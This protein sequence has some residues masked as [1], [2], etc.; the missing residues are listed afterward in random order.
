MRDKIDEILDIFGRDKKTLVY[1]IIAYALIMIAIILI[2]WWPKEKEYA[3]YQKVDITT[4]KTEQ[5]QQYIDDLTYIF[6]NSKKE[7]FAES[8]SN[9]YLEYTNKTAQSIISELESKNYFSS[10][11]QVKGLNIYEDGETYVYS[12]TMYSGNNSR[13]INI[14]ETYPYEY[15]IVFDDFYSYTTYDR[16]TTKNNIKFTVNS[17]YR[18]LRYLDIDMSIENLNDSN[19]GFDFNSTVGVQAVLTDGNTYSLSNLVSSGS[20]TTLTPNMTVNKQLVFEV[21]AQLQEN[22]EYIVFVGVNLEFS[23]AN[24]K[25]SL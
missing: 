16:A 9:G 1:V 11:V 15:E 24:I 8:I 6:K 23:K 2:I 18:N 17:I 20:C 5:G 3:T 12:T 10:D 13:V 19:V 21:P 14:I 4:R 7:E 25:I 22:I